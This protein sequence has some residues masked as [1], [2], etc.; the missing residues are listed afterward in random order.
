[1]GSRNERSQWTE[2]SEAHR[3]EA[4]V[5][6]GH[7]GISGAKHLQGWQGAGCGREWEAGMKAKLREKGLWG[8]S[9]TFTPRLLRTLAGPECEKVLGSPRM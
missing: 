3:R 7:A 4:E 5:R 2:R 8:R 1:M 9:S 6:D